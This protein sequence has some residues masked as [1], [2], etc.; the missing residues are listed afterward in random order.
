MT[1]RS[2]TRSHETL[3]ASAT[4]DSCAWS[5]TV[6][7]SDMNV[8]VYRAAKDHAVTTPNHRTTVTLARQHHY[9]ARTTAT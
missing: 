8:S 4:C 9:V 3:P 2:L 6:T 5:W 1:R 7:H